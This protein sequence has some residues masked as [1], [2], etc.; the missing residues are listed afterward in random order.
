MAAASPCAT[1]RVTSHA[2]YIRREQ[3]NGKRQVRRALVSSTMSQ[4]RRL[5]G[6]SLT[7]HFGCVNA[8]NFSNNGGQLILSGGDDR[9][10]LVWR[11]EE[12]VSQCCRPIALKT[13][14]ASN[15][16]S[17]LFDNSNEHVYSA[18]NDEV[19]LRHNLERLVAID[20]FP[21]RQPVYGVSVDPDH[22]GIFLSAGDDGRVLLWDTR[23]PE[24]PC[25]CVARYTRPF[26]AAVFHPIEP[27]FVATANAGEGVG[28][29]DI[30]QPQKCLTMYGGYLCKQKA[31]SVAFD[32]S[33]QHILALR[34]RLPAVLFNIRQ[35]LPVC[36][37]THDGYMNSCTMKSASFC[38][39]ND[40][41][42][43][44]GS[45]DFNVYVWKIPDAVYHDPLPGN[46]VGEADCVLVG[47]RSIVNQVRFNSHSM[48]LLSSG[49]E[50]VIKLWSPFAISGKEDLSDLNRK[51]TRED[52][53][54]RQHFTPREQRRLVLSLNSPYETD[55]YSLQSIEE[56]SRMLSFFDSLLQQD[57][58]SDGASGSSVDTVVMGMGATESRNSDNEADIDT[59]ADENAQDEETSDSHHH[60]DF[61]DLMQLFLSG[62]YSS[63][64]SSRSSSSTSPSDTDDDVS[65]SRESDHLFAPTSSTSCG[66]EQLSSYSPIRCSTISEDD[67]SP[68][69]RGHEGCDGINGVAVALESA[70]QSVNSSAACYCET[71]EGEQLETA[72]S[73]TYTSNS[74]LLTDTNFGCE[75]QERHNAE[76]T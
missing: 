69:N 43:A 71:V 70:R 12:A 23:M 75:E 76:L 15:I 63:S 64:L 6:V 54:Q 55:P 60:V 50:K 7:G 3:L 35:A 17:T 11:T 28:L 74:I 40:E 45:D 66:E 16:F 27:R 48:Y 46:W 20:I 62:T 19:V 9:R 4:R 2:Y 65:D 30:R 42:V 26:H 39:D 14:H 73:R 25:T 67:S 10:V 32:R 59:N 53:R 72:H 13:E 21:H 33:G 24:S 68:F 61:R 29:W 8:V 47:H 34:R 37:F 57:E 5:D 22:D 51:V 18:G 41:Y 49:V 38:G 58:M 36:Q 52:G 31:M 56:D 1:S 44:S